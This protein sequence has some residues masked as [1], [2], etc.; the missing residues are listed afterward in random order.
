M[1]EF[2]EFRCPSSNVV[3]YIEVDYLRCD[4]AEAN[5]SPPPRPGGLVRLRA[6]HHPHSRRQRRVCVRRAQL[7]R[8]TAALSPT[9]SQSPRPLRCDSV[10]P[11]ITCRDTQTGQGFSI[12]REAYQLF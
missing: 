7:L 10:E 2:T 4:I 8:P 1:Y 6:G 9:V 5:C 12:S 3:C 11:G